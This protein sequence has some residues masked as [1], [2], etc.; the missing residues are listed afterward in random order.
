MEHI[1]VWRERERERDLYI[2]VCECMDVVSA[3]MCMQVPQRPVDG[4]RYPGA[5][6]TG[7]CEPINVGAGNQAWVL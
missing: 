2:F 4:I 6:I 1:H 7:N 5:G 3:S